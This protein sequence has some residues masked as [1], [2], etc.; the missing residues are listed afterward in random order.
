MIV[1]LAVGVLLFGRRLPEV[2]R[3]LGKGIIDFKKGE[4]TAY[5]KQP[6]ER[7]VEQ[8]MTKR[9][10]GIWQKQFSSRSWV[11][12]FLIFASL[13]SFL[14]LVPD[15][16]LKSWLVGCLAVIVV[17]LVLAK[18]L[19]AGGSPPKP[20]DEPRPPDDYDHPDP[21]NPRTPFAGSTAAKAEREAEDWIDESA[22]AGSPASP[23]DPLTQHR[24]GSLPA[25]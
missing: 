2:G 13:T 15:M 20:P 24:P 16:S 19:Q 14:I 7:G 25:S 22:G 18:R 17:V 6:L 4:R 21:L 11:I 8:A 12:V 1:I 10:P 23:W 5:R 3:Y 9:R